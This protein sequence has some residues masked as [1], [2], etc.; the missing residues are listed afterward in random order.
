MRYSL[1]LPQLP[2]FRCNP[3]DMKR[4]TRMW[5]ELTALGAVIAAIVIA[6][7]HPMTVSIPKIDATGPSA[8]RIDT[9]ATVAATSIVALIL[10]AILGLVLWLVRN[11]VRR[12]TKRDAPL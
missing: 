8:H 4:R 5:C 1:Y 10:I 3:S 6:G 11:I 7:S 2:R 9:M 12:G